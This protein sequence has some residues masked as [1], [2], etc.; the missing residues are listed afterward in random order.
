MPV[1]GLALRRLRHQR[2]PLLA[3]HADPDQGAD[4]RA[5]LLGLLGRQLGRLNRLDLAVALGDEE[6]V[7][8]ADEA[9]VGQPLELRQDL[10]RERGLFGADHEHL[11]RPERKCGLA[12]HVASSSFFF[13]A[14]NSS[15][16]RTPSS[17]SFPSFS[18]WRDEVVGDAAR[19][20]AARRPAPAAGTAAAAAEIVDL[21]VLLLLLGLPAGRVL[22]EHVRPAADHGGPGE[23]SSASEHSRFLSFLARPLPGSE[24]ERRGA[25]AAARPRRPS[26]ATT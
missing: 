5:E 15:W 25:R 11:D 8:E 1:L 7:D 13:C 9:L 24:P 20:C 19:R 22:A 10:A 23:W 6:E 16:V 14:S 26:T 12:A 4:Q 18:S 3:G 21:G 2:A 17:L